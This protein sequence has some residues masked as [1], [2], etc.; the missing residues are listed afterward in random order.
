MED[1]VFTTQEHKV[2]FHRFAH[3]CEARKARLRGDKKKN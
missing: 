2:L 3:H 1:E